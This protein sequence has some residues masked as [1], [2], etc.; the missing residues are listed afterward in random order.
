MMQRPAM[1]WCASC[2][3]WTERLGDTQC[4]LSTAATDWCRRS[5][6]VDGSR[7]RARGTRTRIPVY[8]P[9]PCTGRG[10]GFRRMPWVFHT[11]VTVARAASAHPPRTAGE[12]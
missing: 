6:V 5:P 1:A 7:G 8:E 9:G 12:P 11:W 2:A 4:R 3:S 10:G